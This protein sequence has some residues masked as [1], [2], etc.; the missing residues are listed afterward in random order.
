MPEYRVPQVDVANLADLEP[1]TEG[2]S[3]P[4]TE[5]LDAGIPAMSPAEQ[6]IADRVAIYGERAPKVMEYYDTL[7]FS[8]RSVLAHIHD[9]DERNRQAELLAEKAALRMDMSRGQGYINH[10]GNTSEAD[11][12]F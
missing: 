11:R 7:K 12:R 1:P 3:E 6:L 2:F 5:V 4:S 10:P 9:I 8:F